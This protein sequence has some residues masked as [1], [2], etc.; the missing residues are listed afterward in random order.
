MLFEWMA[1]LS[2]TTDKEQLFIK[3]KMSWFVFRIIMGAHLGSQIMI[4]SAL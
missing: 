2:M 1:I 4:Q 3:L